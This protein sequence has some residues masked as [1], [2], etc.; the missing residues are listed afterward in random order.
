[1]GRDVKEEARG[2]PRFAAS[3]EA[4][5]EG[6][7]QIDPFLGPCDPHIAQSA[8][9]LHLIRVIE[10]PSVR[11]EPLLHAHDEDDWKLQP[12]GGMEG[13]QGHRIDLL[14]VTIHIGN[15]SHPLKKGGK[16][17]LRR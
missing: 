14:I 3:K 4:T 7:H 10:G 17:I 15:E 5:A 1:V 2:E 8:L 12:L 11:E 16:A 13:D 6:T 9:L